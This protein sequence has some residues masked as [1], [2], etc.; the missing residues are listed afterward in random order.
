MK[1]DTATQFVMLEL[2]G[3]YEKAKRH[4]CYGL[5]RI[6]KHLVEEAQDTVC[7]IL[8]EDSSSRHTYARGSLK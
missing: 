5:P 6:A 4:D 7:A 2:A 3:R 8:Y 1:F